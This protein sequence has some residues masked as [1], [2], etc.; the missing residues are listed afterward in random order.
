MRQ[1]PTDGVY[2]EGLCELVVKTREDIGRLVAQGNG[3]R[4]VAATQ[5]NETSSRSHSV[6]AL[7][8]EQKHTVTEGSVERQTTL[9]SKVNLV[10]LAGSERANKTGAEGDTL[11]EGIEINKSLMAL[12]MVIKSL[13]EGKFPTYRASTLTFL[14][15]DSLGGNAATSMLAAISPA[16][17]NYDETHSTLQY[18]QRAKTITN[19]VVKNEDV[20]QR[21]VRELKEEIERLRAQLT[22]GGGGGSGGGGEGKVVEWGEGKGSE[23]EG[24]AV[25]R[26]LLQEKLAALERA[27]NQSWDERIAERERL[28][29]ELE[30]ER[31]TN[32]GRTLSDRIEEVKRRKLV[33]IEQLR[34]LQAEKESLSKTVR[35]SK[36]DKK[37]LG[38]RLDAA[39]GVYEGMQAKR[40]KGEGGDALV[41]AM[42]AQMKEVEGIN[43]AIAELKRATKAA[44]SRLAE[45]DEEIDKLKA[46]ILATSD[47]LNDNDN[48][49]KK[50]QEEERAKWE[51]EK[52][53]LLAEERAA[54]ERQ[55]AEM[56]AE[57]VSLAQKG[58]EDTHAEIEALRSQ[59]AAERAKAADSTSQL[60]F[61]DE[62]IMQ[63]KAENA[64]LHDAVDISRLDAT[65]LEGEKVELGYRISE[66]E[67][68]VTDLDT[69]V[70][71]AESAAAT[72][73]AAAE[74]AKRQLLLTNTGEDD[75]SS[76]EDADLHHF[77]STLDVA[78]GGV[79]EGIRTA[80][81]TQ[82]S[83]APELVPVSEAERLKIAQE[84]G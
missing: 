81:A 74:A 72:A 27:Q 13:S 23:D 58:A 43:A 6:L 25:E 77:E 57:R 63:L 7:R 3:V 54:M 76:L 9:S 34:H 35:H 30:K 75:D 46:E 39:V 59:L 60:R 44:P 45:L 36:K 78:E 29:L 17:Y 41:K 4:R 2:V 52:V 33:I 66:L 32:L 21:V 56:A 40:A 53:Q 62:D 64:R 80:E 8:V 50:I 26:A 20:N 82:V 55:A 69:A 19:K 79:L 70:K 68:R 47:M 83:P 15:K 1:H 28:T 12:G 71:S 84:P 10:D 11:K 48:L 67:A 38:K 73:K 49:R 31:Q 42:A 51:V 24:A 61:A 65:N 5:M 37:D 16:D 22:G 14:L 18:A